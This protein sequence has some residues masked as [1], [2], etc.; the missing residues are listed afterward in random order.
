MKQ[1]IIAILS[2]AVLFFALAFFNQTWKVSQL[3]KELSSTQHELQKTK[4]KASNQKDY[5]QS[6]MLDE[7]SIEVTS[8]LE[9]TF[10]KFF[11]Y[12]NRTYIKRFDVLSGRASKDVINMLKGGI[13]EKTAPKISFYNETKDLQVYVSKSIKDGNMSAL[14]TVDSV[15]HANSNDFE[16]NDLYRITLTEK[17]GKLLITSVEYL[18]P[19]NP[20]SHT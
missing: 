7:K 1:L 16:R 13:S 15:Y 19:F 8:F 3:N 11:N 6:Y 20:L 10:T 5:I 18:S 2:A 17:N 9:D 12:D 4:Q 14:M